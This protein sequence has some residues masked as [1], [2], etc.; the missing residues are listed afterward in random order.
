M[1]LISLSH[2]VKKYRSGAEHVTALDNVS[3]GIEPAQMTV[4]LGPSGSGKSTALNML[5]GMDTPTSGTIV[6]AGED[7][8]SF[9]DARLTLYR[10]DQVGFVF[11]HYNLIPNL[12]AAENVGLGSQFSRDA[13]SPA[14]A[15]ASVGLTGRERSFPSELSGGQMQRVAIA[16]AIAKR[17]R[18]LL[19]DEPTGAL[20]SETGRAVITL[21]RSI[22]GTTET[23]VVVVT[24]NVSV[25]AVGDAAVSLHDGRIQSHV[26]HQ[27]P[28][29]VEE[30][31]W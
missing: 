20:D 9:D 16:R 31:D 15:L 25:G 10:R 12:T 19:C 23:A 11:Q 21:L 1:T 22:A 13:M 14:E 29:S 6:A 2:V 5:G 4:I 8:S 7:I 26:E 30:I 24:H 17:P 18:L 3:F 27:V 28:T